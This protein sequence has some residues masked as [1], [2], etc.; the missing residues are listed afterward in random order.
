MTRATQLSTNHGVKSHFLNVLGALHSPHDIVHKFHLYWVLGGAAKTASELLSG[1][2]LAEKESSSRHGG[3]ES[4]TL[5]DCSW[6][7]IIMTSFQK[8]T[9]HKLMFSNNVKLV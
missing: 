6:F 5:L 2:L 3:Q 8:S 9:Q 1:F 7:S 4:G